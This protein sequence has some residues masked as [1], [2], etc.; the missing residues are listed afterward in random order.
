MCLLK[1][2]IAKAPLNVLMPSAEVS[3]MDWHSTMM[4][5][6]VR[7]VERWEGRVISINALNGL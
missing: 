6:P 2:R 3:I 1:I 5:Q 4:N 7:E